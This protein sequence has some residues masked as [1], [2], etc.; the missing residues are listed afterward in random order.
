[1]NIIISS[2]KTT[3]REDF[4]SRVE[5]KLAKL[6][7]FFGE[8]SIVNLTVTNEGERETVEITITS[9][10]LYFRA[11]ETTDERIK[12]FDLAFDSILRQIQK[13]KDKLLKRMKANSFD[14]F[15]PFSGNDVQEDEYKVVRSKTF[16]VKPMD[17]EE[18]IL[19]MNMLGHNFFMFRNGA[20][21][22]INVVYKRK[23]GNYGLIEPEV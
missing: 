9:N 3:I 13:N 2:R 20:T 19:Q 17:L 16:P 8:D 12:S 10:G 6:E 14:Y 18:A 23:D 4:R 5:R 15:E 1:M 11:E 7:K 22:E 21:E